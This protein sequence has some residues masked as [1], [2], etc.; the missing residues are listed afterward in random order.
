MEKTNSLNRFKLRP[1]HIYLAVLA[2]IIFF[3]VIAG[4]IVL[5]KGCPLPI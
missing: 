2:T 3:G 5:I 4:L 1:F